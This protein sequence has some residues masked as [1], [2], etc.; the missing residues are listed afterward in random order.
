[1]IEI[2][3]EPILQ[4]QPQP[5]TVFRALLRA[6]A[7]WRISL[8]KYRKHLSV[9]SFVLVDLSGLEIERV[10]LASIAID[11]GCPRIEEFEQQPFL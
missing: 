9:L 8:P 11:L 2:Q 10:L 5:P 4:S 3:H 6:T 1:M 7:T